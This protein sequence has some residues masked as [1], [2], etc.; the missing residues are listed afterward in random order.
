MRRV[1]T[2]LTLSDL[3]NLKITIAHYDK[4][5]IITALDNAVSVY[6]NLRR[7]LYAEDVVLQKEAEKKSMEYFKKIKNFSSD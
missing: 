1:E 3:E 2:E 6:K 4:A 7:K 5:S